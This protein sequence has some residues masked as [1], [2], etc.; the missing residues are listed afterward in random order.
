MVQHYLKVALRNLLKYKSH[1]LISAICLSVGLVCFSMIGYFIDSI[2][3]SVRELPDLE[4][5]V[6]FKMPIENNPDRRPTWIFRLN[7]VKMLEERK[8]PGIE[9]ISYHSFKYDPEMLFIDKEQQ[10]RPFEVSCRGT[11]NAFFRFYDAK[12]LYGDNLPQSPD[13]IIISE[14]CARRIYG[15][16]NPVGTLVAPSSTDEKKDKKTFKIVNVVTDLSMDLSVNADLYIPA[17]GNHYNELQVQGLL[18]PNADFKQINQ[19]LEQIKVNRDSDTMHFT[20]IHLTDQFNDLGR[21]A[22]MTFITF[23]SSLILLSGIINFLKFIIQMFYNRQRELALRKCMGSNAKGLF[24]LLFAEVVWMLTLSFLLS[25]A[26]TEIIVPWMHT[27]VPKEKMIP[28]NVSELCWKQFKVFL[29]LL[30][31]CL[32]VIIIPIRRLQSVSIIHHISRN[33][34]R[35]RFRNVMMGVQ[36]CVCIFFLGIA[37]GLVIYI[38]KLDNSI[39]KPLTEVQ[40]EQIICLPLN[41]TSLKKQK[42]A[43]LAEVQQ[44]P[45]VDRII[46]TSG[47]P[48]RNS[49]SYTFTTYEQKN[50]NNMYLLIQGGTPAYFDFFQ[51]PLQGGKVDVDAQGMIYISESFANQLEK[52][53]IQGMV[54]LGEETYRIGGIYKGLYGENM[55]SL[56]TGGSVFFI[57]QDANSYY[58]H[59]KENS[60][61]EIVKKQIQTICRRHVPESIPLSLITLADDKNFAYSAIEMSRD[62]TLILAGVSILLVILSIY[63]SISMDTTNRQKEVAIRKVNGATPRVIALIFGKSYCVIYILAFFIAFPLTYLLTVKMAEGKETFTLSD[64]WMWGIGLFISI[65]ALVVLTTGFKI[66]RI[67]HINPSKIIKTE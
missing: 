64:I 14:S 6:D 27:Y 12:L 9:A 25:L 31:I 56:K 38:I 22:V 45:E 15:D 20:A 3:S 65:A 48:R 58:F 52:D 18:S 55:Q 28:M 63:S 67:M 2:D 36:L 60:N 13:E 5:R 29:Q 49:N 34:G 35:H 32:I 54:K 24:A 61:V 62:I 10:E 40:T 11:N 41:S 33:N 43:I 53:S 16:Q 47:N 37:S 51:I 59:I 26:L 8:V 7:E 1:S 39:Y 17:E 30:F 21:L 23:L 4:R 57:N 19:A 42:E 44:L 66:Y 46:F 50:G